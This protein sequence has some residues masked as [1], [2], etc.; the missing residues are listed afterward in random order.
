MR[1]RLVRWTFA[2]LA[3]ALL[4]AVCY[5]AEAAPD[6]KIVESSDIG[7]YWVA[8][9]GHRQPPPRYPATSVREGIESC[10]EV[11][12]SIEADGIPARM[13]VLRSAFGS[14]ARQET[15][16]AL[17]QAA[18]DSVA[19]AR[20]E[21]GANNPDHLPVYTHSVFTFTLNDTRDSDAKRAAQS[22]KIKQYSSIPNLKEYLAT[23]VKQHA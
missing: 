16:Q 19:A 18:I 8:Q 2:A 6:Y 14:G 12:F 10:I 3:G 21:A 4:P 17:R 11:G 15:T 9:P 22:E 1:A 7:L 20:Y 23:Q 13:V 5:C